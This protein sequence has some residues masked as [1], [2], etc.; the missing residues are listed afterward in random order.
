MITLCF[1]ILKRLNCNGLVERWKTTKSHNFRILVTKSPTHWVDRLTSKRDS[2]TRNEVPYN[3]PCF[4]GH[5]L[6][7]WRIVHHLIIMCWFSDWHTIWIPQHRLILSLDFGLVVEH[8]HF[9]RQRS[10][11]SAPSPSGEKDAC[12]RWRWAG[13]RACT[14][15]LSTINRYKTLGEDRT[16]SQRSVFPLW[17]DSSSASETSGPIPCT[18]FRTS[19][20]TNWIKNHHPVGLRLFPPHYHLDLHPTKI[21]QIPILLQ[22]RQCP[23]EPLKRQHRW[24]SVSGAFTDGGI[25]DQ[26]PVPVS[27]PT[28][29]GCTV[30]SKFDTAA[31]DLLYSFLGSHP[32][33]HG[34]ARIRCFK[35]QK[36]DLSSR[37]KLPCW[38]TERWSYNNCGHVK[39]AARPAIWHRPISRC[40]DSCGENEL[41]PAWLGERRNCERGLSIQW[42]KAS[43]VDGLD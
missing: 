21:E 23:S 37:P 41:A 12:R 40:V 24:P 14:N 25:W 11:Q 33:P 7:I 43:A 42:A 27:V 9:N 35:T 4:C 10:P 15:A 30:P 36:C 2:C 16:G 34:H 39:I 19:F 6:G 31:S 18:V 32:K 22:L 38:T 8:P 5:S 17:P 20:A 3:S 1:K 26:G 29:Q 28:I 13:A